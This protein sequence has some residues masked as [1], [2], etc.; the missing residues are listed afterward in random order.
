VK[1]AMAAVTLF[2]TLAACTST[3]RHHVVGREPS[4]QDRKG[5]A[6]PGPSGTKGP[7]AAGSKLSG[8]YL[9]LVSFTPRRAGIADT[10]HVRG[11]HFR[12]P[13]WPY[14]PGKASML[15]DYMGNQGPRDCLLEAT[16]EDAAFVQA[17]GSVSGSFRVPRGGVCRQHEP[18]RRPRIVP[19]PYS[20]SLGCTSCVVGRFLVVRD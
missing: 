2:V 19:G 5:S 7:C 3:P 18:P 1:R 17:N 20:V 16:I 12:G 15:F 14:R 11:R 13:C 10:V 4:A 9:P 6:N 8:G